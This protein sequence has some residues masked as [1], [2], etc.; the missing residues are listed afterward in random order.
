MHL[1]WCGRAWKNRARRFRYERSCRAPTFEITN[2][3]A[4]KTRYV[5]G[6]VTRAL[7]SA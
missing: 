1:L 7:N 2:L 3:S 4:Q 6:S 5:N